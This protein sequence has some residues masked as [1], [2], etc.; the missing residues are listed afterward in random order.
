MLKKLELA[1]TFS[2]LSKAKPDEPIFVIRAK[3]EL[4]S[5]TL[6]LWAAMAEGIHEPEKISE[7]LQCAEDMDKWRKDNIVTNVPVTGN[8]VPGEAEYPYTKMTR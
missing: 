4:A 5:Q 7:A 1:K 6:R 3:D 8:S 2:C